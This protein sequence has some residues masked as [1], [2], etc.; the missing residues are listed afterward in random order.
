MILE[1]MKTFLELSVYVGIIFTF[2]ITV[3]VMEA[4][5]HRKDLDKIQKRIDKK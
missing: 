3:I 4:K 1:F 5:Q 2:A